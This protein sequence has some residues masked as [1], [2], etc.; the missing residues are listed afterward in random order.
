MTLFERLLGEG[1]PVWLRDIMVDGPSLQHGALRCDPVPDDIA[2]D[3]IELVAVSQ[4]QAIRPR[5][6]VASDEVAGA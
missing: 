2:N 1:S 3:L 4:T 6:G 5:H